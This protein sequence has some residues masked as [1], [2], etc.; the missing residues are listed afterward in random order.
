MTQIMTIKEIQAIG[1]LFL[2]GLYIGHIVL[3][4]IKQLNDYEK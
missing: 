4:T 3:K 2:L 1:L